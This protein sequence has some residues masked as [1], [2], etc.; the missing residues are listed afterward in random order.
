[1]HIWKFSHHLLFLLAI[2]STAT[3]ADVIRANKID[4]FHANVCGKFDGLFLCAKKIE[5]IELNKNKNI[6]EREGS[7]L[8]LKAENKKYVFNSES[9]IRYFLIRTTKNYFVLTEIYD[10][11]W[12]A[13]LISR[14]TGQATSIIGLPLFNPSKTKFLCLS[15]DLDAGIN[16]NALQVWSDSKGDT[17]KVYEINSFPQKGGPVKARWINDDEIEIHT[18]NLDD[19]MNEKPSSSYQMKIKKLKN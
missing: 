17:N 5:K 13:K 3:H 12:N 1:M 18:I 2:I 10:Q 15:L 8:I 6:S 4:S 16:P 7:K 19:M 11:G 9:D 14:K